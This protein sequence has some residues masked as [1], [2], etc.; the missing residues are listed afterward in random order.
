MMTNAKCIYV[1]DDDDEIRT[2]LKTYLEKH[3]FT[4]LT[5]DSGEAFLAN[6][7]AEQEVDLVILDIMLPGQDGF[8]VCRSLRTQSQVPVIML[9]ANSDEMDRIIGLEIGADDYLAKPF[10]PRELLARIK[11]ILRRM[12]HTEVI[13]IAPVAHRFYRFAQFTL[14]TLSRELHFKDEKESLSGA[15]YNLLM[16]FLTHPGAVLTRELIAENTRGRDSAPLDRFIDVHVSRLRQRLREDARQPQL[17][18]TI[19]GQGYILT[20]S[21]EAISDAR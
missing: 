14:D 6:F 10:N 3:Q 8:A 20:A 11:A 17:I 4:V 19:R 7:R 21:V 12:E 5:A 2:L 16:L 18:K 1:V 9:T 13:E 15:D